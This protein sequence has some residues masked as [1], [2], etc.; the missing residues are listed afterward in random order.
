MHFRLPLLAI[1]IVLIACKTEMKSSENIEESV[2]KAYQELYRPQYHFTPKFGWMNDPNGL[3]HHDGVYH[4]FYQYYPY[5]TVWGPMH[6]GHAVSQ[7]MVH[8]EHKPIALYPDELGLIFSGSAVVDKNNT[9]G[10]GP[11]S[12]REDGKIPLVAIFT[13]HN[14]QGEKGG[15]KTFQ[16]QGIAYSLDN[17]ETW[18][19][20]EGNP[21]LGNN[22]IRDLR[23][24]KVFWHEDSQSWIMTLVAGDHAKFYRSKNLREWDNIS[25]FGKGQGSK[26]GV[27]ECPDLFKLEVEGSDEEKWVL[28]ISVGNGAPNGGSGTQYFVGDFDGT[29]FTSDQMD[30]KWLDWGTDNYAGVTYNNAPNGNRIFI[31]W[32]SNWQYALKTPASTWRS[33]MSLPRKLSLKKINGDYL[34]YNYPLPSVDELV[35]TSEGETI[36]ISTKDMYTTSNLSL[37]QSKISFL[38]PAKDFKL[39][40]SNKV[41]EKTTLILDAASSLLMLDRTG[42]GN[43]NFNYEFGNKLHYTPMKDISEKLE[44]SIYLD[45]S[46]IEVFV[47]GGQYAM[48]DQLFPS[49]AYTQLSIENLSSGELE[50]ENLNI[51]SMQSVWKWN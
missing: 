8:W 27:W 18:T 6:W 26:G 19:K 21:V 42:S 3:V 12:Y 45:W 30:Y 33:A 37:G 29:T 1:S 22:G 35:G 23:D 13:Y 10:F 31:G 28:I 24:P 9:S 2:F 48:T 44:F 50:I 17:G 46:S 36:S 32:M 7:D 47:N 25:D 4:L 49:Q 34:L 11:D 39:T 14:I 40:L 51:S 5:A 20:Y 43:T 15:S 41:G 16:T 38:A